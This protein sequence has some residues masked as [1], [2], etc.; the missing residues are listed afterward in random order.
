MKNW[1]TKKLYISVALVKL[2]QQQKVESMKIKEEPKKQFWRQR[3]SNRNS[4]YL[5]YAYNI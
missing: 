3:I 4:S 5:L 1:N 2:A